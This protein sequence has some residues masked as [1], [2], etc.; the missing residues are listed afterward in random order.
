MPACR[1]HANEE[2]ILSSPN[3]R[4]LCI[5]EPVIASKCS[6][7]NSAA[8]MPMTM[9]QVRVTVSR[10]FSSTL[11]QLSSRVD[12]YPSTERALKYCMEEFNASSKDLRTCKIASGDHTVRVSA[13]SAIAVISC[14]ASVTILAQH[15]ISETRPAQCPAFSFPFSVIV[16]HR[17]SPSRN[18]P[19]ARRITV[20]R[21][22]VGPVRCSSPFS[23]PGRNHHKSYNLAAG[24]CDWGICNQSGPHSCHNSNTNK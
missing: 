19:A 5:P 13:S 18:S 16:T 23:F 7:S 20:H 1:A 17:P 4:E 21:G 3:A 9:L 22:Q 24:D 15:W 6:I 2:V 14:T 12:Q 11:R 10:S 8:M